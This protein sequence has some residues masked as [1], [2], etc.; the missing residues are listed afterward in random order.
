[1]KIGLIPVN[2][3]VPNAEAMVGMAQLAE[4]VGF[5]SVWT[6]EHAIVPLDYQS[7]YPYSPTGKMG[8]DPDANFVD[9]LI[10]L[11]AVAAQTKTIRLG[12]GVNIL[13]QANP[14][15]VAK[16]AASLDFVSNGRFE[17]GIGIGW[18]RE[19]FVAAGTPFE[20]RGARFDDYIQAMRKIWSGEVVEHKSEYIDWSGFK[21]KPAPVQDPFPVVIGGTKGKAFERTARYGNG[22]FAP[23]A[24]P[25]QL[26]PLMG[27]LDAA[28][29][30]VGRDRA[31]IQVTSM[32][33]PNAADLSDVERYTE[34]GVSRLVVMLPALGKG[35]PADNMKAFAENV[36]SKVS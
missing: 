25:D 32:W 18:L 17:L 14:L 6:F 15:Y 9:P 30:E 21:S 1:M 4:S 24:S 33:F 31:D 28:C 8:V 36:I 5:E 12:T 10:A 16:Q 7:K 23:T 34:M 11:T 20:K 19:E 22:W 27:E 29:K 26:A 13:P 35:N 3:G 2:V